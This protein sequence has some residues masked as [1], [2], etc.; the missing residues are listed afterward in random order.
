MS[1]GWKPLHR[2]RE[3]SAPTKMHFNMSKRVRNSMPAVLAPEKYCTHRLAAAAAQPVVG[4][5]P[6]KSWTHETTD[7]FVIVC[8]LFLLALSVIG[9]GFLIVVVSLLWVFRFCFSCC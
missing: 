7:F 4:L 6:E 8:S 2:F 1:H 5:S 9:A 3:P